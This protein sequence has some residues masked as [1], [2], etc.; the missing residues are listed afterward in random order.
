MS[1]YSQFSFVAP[2]TNADGSPLT[3]FPITYTVLVDT[4]NP[5]VKA[6]PIPAADVTVVAGVIT[7]TFAQIGF[8]PAAN[9]SYFAAVEAADAAGTSALSDIVTFNEAVVPAA[10]TGFKVG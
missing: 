6:F 10:P 3:T 5:P 1:M 8:T 9:T 2:T 7:V 4:V